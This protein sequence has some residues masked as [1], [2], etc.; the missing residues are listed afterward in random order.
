MFDIFLGLPYQ[1]ARCIVYHAKSHQ[2]H[3]QDMG[4]TYL[5]TS[6]LKSTKR[7]ISN[8]GIPQVSLNRCDSSC[9]VFSIPPDHLSHPVPLDMPPI[10]NEN[11]N[12]FS[13]P[14]GLPPPRPNVYPIDLLLGASLPDAPSSRF[15]HCEAAEPAQQIPQPLTWGHIQSSLPCASPTVILSTKDSSEGCL[16][17]DYHALNL[18][19]VTNRSTLPRIEEL[20]DH[21]QEMELPVYYHPLRMQATTIWKIDF[22][23]N[24]GPF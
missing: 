7:L 4:R 5:L 19:T 9:L 22:K 15:T 12:V 10:Q 3:L 8:M 14:T 11:A 17:T 16:V 23:M 18:A 24:F 20:L 6:A 1:Q 13:Q 21:S 2:Y